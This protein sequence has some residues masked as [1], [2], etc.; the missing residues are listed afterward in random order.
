MWF[1]LIPVIILA[2]ATFTGGALEMT[3]KSTS[4]APNVPMNQTPAGRVLPVN[5][6]VPGADPPSRMR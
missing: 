4:A 2:G 1:F 3:S 5:G 6:A